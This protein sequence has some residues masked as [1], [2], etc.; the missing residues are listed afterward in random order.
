MS[1]T[2]YWCRFFYAYTLILFYLGISGI[3]I[4]FYL[5]RIRYQCKTAIGIESLPK[6]LFVEERV[7]SYDEE[8][9]LYVIQ[10]KLMKEYRSE[11]VGLKS[12]MPGIFY[13]ASYF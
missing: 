13:R 6:Y 7:L 2:D 3:R 8:C 9:F 4:R 1:G 12:M 10:C 11:V 5:V